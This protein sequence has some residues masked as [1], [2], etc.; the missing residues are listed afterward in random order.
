MPCDTTR[1]AFGNNVYAGPLTLTTTT[2][3]RVRAFKAGFADSEVVTATFFNSNSV[4]TGTGLR[5]GGPWA[6]QGGRT[7]GAKH[8]QKLTPADI[9]AHVL[10]PHLEEGA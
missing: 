7:R 6:E 3:L 2:A 5:G 10:G 1:D 4:G 9:F 8:G